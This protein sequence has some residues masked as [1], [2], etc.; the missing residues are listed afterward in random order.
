MLAAGIADELARKRRCT[1]DASAARSDSQVPVPSPPRI[2]NA[3]TTVK[4]PPTSTTPDRTK[5]RPRRYTPYG[6]VP[7]KP[8]QPITDQISAIQAHHHRI[9]SHDYFLT[10]PEYRGT[11]KRAK[12]PTGIWGFARE[13]VERYP[14]LRKRNFFCIQHHQATGTPF[15]YAPFPSLSLQG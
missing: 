11:A 10:A 3:V 4:P 13:D 6:P 2:Q 7:I 8:S 5:T 1:N 14:M 12:E 9:A 15:P